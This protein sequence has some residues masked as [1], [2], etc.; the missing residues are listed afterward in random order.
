MLRTVKLYS[1]LLTVVVFAASAWAQ[2]DVKVEPVAAPA[3]S[4]VPQ[5]LLD[6]MD[7]Q[8]ARVAGEKGTI[9]EIWLRKGMTLGPAAGGLGDI[10]YGQLGAGNLV[11]VLHFPSQGADFRGNPVK[12]GYYALRYAL[13]P[14]DGAH[15]GVYATRDSLALT[16]VSADTQVEQTLSFDD[17]VKLSKQASGTPH[18][19]FLIMG[20]VADGASFPSIGKDDHGH[21]NLQLK[22]QGKNGELP[23]AITVVGVWAGE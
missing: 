7:S 3:A 1:T 10:M 18:P 22:L 23:I 6:V 19:A 5:A 11:G 2:G 9:C 20:A 21:S 16:P 14:Q 13:I 4:D 15:M 17:V 12:A 8:G